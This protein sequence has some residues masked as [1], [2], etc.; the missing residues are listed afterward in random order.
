MVY[1]REPHPRLPRF[2]GFG[3]G[4]PPPRDL[5]VLLAVV[6]VTFT[7]QFF[8]GT[9]TLVAFL[10][11][12]PLVWQL[13]LLWQLV[14][15]PFAGYGGPSLWFLLELLILFW[16]GR[17][18]FYRLGR[19]GFWTTLGVAALAAGVVAVLVQIMGWLVTGSVG[20][21]DFVI[22]QGQRMLLAMTIAAFA[23]LMGDATIYLFFVLPVRA[24]WFLWIEI[25]FAFMA[26]LGTK[27]LPGFLGLCTAVAAVWLWLQG[28][29]SRRL[30]R[31]WWLRLQRKWIQ[32]RLRGR[33]RKSGFEV[34]PGDKAD[35]GPYIH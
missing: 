10:R 25:L 15:Y 11:L 16:F 28:S 14:T 13:G 22:L 7:F 6:F 4:A 5:V 27:D 9:D 31:E 26:Y 3:T 21:N 18:V 34:I 17:D 33:R 19:R 1:G 24:R 30:L 29:R 35:R 23:T 32:W 12:T 2:G 8:P 20:M